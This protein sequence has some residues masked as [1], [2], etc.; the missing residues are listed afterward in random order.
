VRLEKWRPVL[1]L[2]QSFSTKFKYPNR[3]TLLDQP[4][5]ELG[6]DF[7]VLGVIGEARREARPLSQ[8][9]LQI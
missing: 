4:C 1:Y 9:D 5:L 7:R 2:F 3:V 6:F 8:S